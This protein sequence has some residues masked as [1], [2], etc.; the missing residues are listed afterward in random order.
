MKDALLRS[1]IYTIFK[2]IVFWTK[3]EL[4]INLRHPP[5]LSCVT[6]SVDSAERDTRIHLYS[7]AESH[8]N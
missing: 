8:S 2:W 5:C 3:L 4:E 7:S 6:I 1:Y